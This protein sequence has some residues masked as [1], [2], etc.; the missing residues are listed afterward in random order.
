MARVRAAFCLLSCRVLLP[1]RQHAGQ[2]TLCANSQAGRI[3]RVA[4]VGKFRAYIAATVA[5]FTLRACARVQRT[6]SRQL[7]TQFTRPRAYSGQSQPCLFSRIP[8]PRLCAPRAFSPGLPSTAPARPGAA[9]CCRVHCARFGLPHVQ[10]VPA[11]PLPL[12]GCRVPSPCLPVS[13][14]RSIVRRETCSAHLPA[15]CTGRGC[16]VGS[17]HRR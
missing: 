1:G 9:P 10:A 4:V 6:D 16:L 8:R 11:P 17:A 13:G 15:V 14:G 2:V 3:A 12:S 5:G 7:A